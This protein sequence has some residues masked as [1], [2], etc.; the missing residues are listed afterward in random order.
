M[1]RLR[2]VN[3]AS[4]NR[5][6][7]FSSICPVEGSGVELLFSD[8]GHGIEAQNLDR[9][10]CPYFSTKVGDAKSGSGLGL[11]SISRYAKDN[12]FDFG[13]RSI[14]GEG[15][16]MILLMPVDQLASKAGSHGSQ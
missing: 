6:D 9:I 16:E 3:L 15:T 1:V 5:D 4:Y 2:Q 14:V 13:V 7:L 10:F 11:S 12:G 8:S